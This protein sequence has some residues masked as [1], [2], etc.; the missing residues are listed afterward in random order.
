L[1]TNALITN[2]LITI[3]RTL[4]SGCG[5]CMDACP[6]GAISLDIDQG[7]STINAALC[8]ECLACMDVCPN[9]AIQTVASTDVVPA[10]AGEVVEGEV[11]GSQVILAAPAELRIETHR[12]GRLA[13][14]TS[15]ALTS[16]GS[17]LLPRAADALLNAVEHRLVGRVDPLPAARPLNSAN[18]AMM[19]PIGGGRGR[20]FRQRQ[21]RRYRQ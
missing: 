17:W 2:A 18:K 14:L 11:I 19:R 8:D 9:D 12:P 10:A 21:R 13:A 4:C 1:T 16:V 6:T 20:R 7:V 3:D 5:E 15:A